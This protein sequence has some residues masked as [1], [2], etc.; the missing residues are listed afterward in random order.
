M[1]VIAIT[2]AKGAPGVTTTTLALAAVWPHRPL[3]AE[4]DPCGGVLAYRFRQSPTPGLI[5]LG[6]AARRGLSPADVWTHTQIISG[7]LPVLLGVLHPEQ[8]AALGP[9]WEE[10]PAA[11]AEVG[12][13]VLIDCG[14]LYPD[15]PTLPLVST[16]DLAI[17]MAWP[18][19]SG[20]TQIQGLLAM[21]ARTG[22]TASIVLAGEQPYRTSE[23]RAALAE[24][25]IAADLLGV[26]AQDR[27]AARRLGG[28][29]G[30]DRALARSPLIRSVRQLA[31]AIAARLD[32]AAQPAR[33]SRPEEVPPDAGS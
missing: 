13:D 15:S 4:C 12:A 1:S 25:G 17:I 24:R 33:P 3:V 9:L 8:A 19:A 5:T 30:S 31:E 14:R 22:T 21:L 6:P 16:A 18:D 10:L 7:S 28:E 2:C 23:V 20:V 11:L 29:P 32:P 27:A 26:M